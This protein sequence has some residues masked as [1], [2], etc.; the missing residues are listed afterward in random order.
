[1]CETA[2]ELYF[3]YCGFRKEEQIVFTDN[4][5]VQFMARQSESD[6]NQVENVL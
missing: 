1:M 5:T 6:V 4:I 3:G 2:V